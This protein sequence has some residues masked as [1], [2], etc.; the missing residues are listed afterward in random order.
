[1]FI[2][3]ALAACSTVKPAFNFCWKYILAIWSVDIP[4]ALAIA[5]CCILLP[6]ANAF[7]TASFFPISSDKVSISFIKAADLALSKLIC[8][9]VKSSASN[10]ASMDDWKFNKL[11]AIPSTS[12][13][14]K[15]N[16]RAAA[17]A[18]CKALGFLPNEVANIPD[19]FAVSF[20]TS[21]TLTALRLVLLKFL[22]TLKV[23]SSTSDRFWPNASALNA[24]LA[25]SVEDNPN[26]SVNSVAAKIVSLLKA[27]LTFI[28]NSLDSD[29]IVFTWSIEDTIEP[30]IELKFEALWPVTCLNSLLALLNSKKDLPI[31]AIIVAGSVIL[32]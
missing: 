6:E 14:D 20:K 19:A 2:S 18:S 28:P 5:C 17:A 22:T 15:P 16:P 32:L 31:L 12:L 26:N 4:I 27:A 13:R 25:A 21:W 11:S 1:M 9:P 24:K 3:A 8:W 30:F 10:S 7:I 29:V 23:S